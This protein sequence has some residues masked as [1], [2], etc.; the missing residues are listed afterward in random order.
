[1]ILLAV[2]SSQ[3]RNTLNQN[4]VL[5]DFAIAA[6]IVV[7]LVIIQIPL[8]I[9]RRAKRHELRKKIAHDQAEPGGTDPISGMAELAA[10]KGWS[11]PS[12]DPQINNQVTEYTHEMLRNLWGHSRQTESGSSS[13]SID[14]QN[15]F[16]NVFHGIIDGRV[17]TI[18]NT[19]L[20]VSRYGTFGPEHGAD[21]WASVCAMHM[22]MTLPPL[23]VN[24]HKCR[25]YRGLMLK[26]SDFESEQFNRTFNVDSVNLKLASDVIT[27][28][29][30]EILLTRDDWAF[31]YQM[32]TLI[33]LCANGLHSAADYQARVDAVSKL[34]DLLPG[35]VAEDDAL[36]MPTMPDGT[37]LSPSMSDEDR[38]KV[39]AQVMAMSP[40]ERTEYMRKAEF[41]GMESFAKM[42]G[43]NI[44][45][46]ALQAAVDKNIAKQQAEH[47]E[48][49]GGAPPAAT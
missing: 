20:N 48:R 13:I 10:S 25:P 24:L 28:Q 47:P 38:E 46:A 31:A 49:F 35:F 29:V 34:I 19:R 2:D 36:K 11:G 4:P 3:I 14:P 18:A 23:Y 39:M 16:S 33:C 43:K 17:F 27:P 1:M 22:P 44:D 9:R 15:R 26:H 41:D 40:E 8:G 45:P 6:V 5:K 32:D 12:T 42:F 7:V 21:G 37:V 30:M